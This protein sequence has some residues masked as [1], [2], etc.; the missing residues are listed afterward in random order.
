MSPLVSTRFLLKAA[1]N[2]NRIGCPYVQSSPPSGR[3][4]QGRG[5]QAKEKT[6]KTKKTRRTA[7]RVKAGENA[8][9]AA[10]RPE[11]GVGGDLFERFEQRRLAALERVK[12]HVDAARLAVDN[13]KLR[14]PQDL[15]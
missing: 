1:L 4:G 9:L 6:K 7:E 14:P 8:V 5:K 15:G 11:E 12:A 10:R 2:R 13:G 3:A